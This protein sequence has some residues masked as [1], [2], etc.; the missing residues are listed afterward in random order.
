MKQ[1]TKSKKTE[2]ASKIRPSFNHKH[3]F[4]IPVITLFCLI[5]FSL[6][7]LLVFGGETI[8]PADSKVVQLHIDGKSQSIPT[9]AATVRELLDRV[10]IEVLPDDVVEP[11][12]DTPITSEK[13]S[14]N[15]YRAKPVVVVDEKGQKTLTKTAETTPRIIAKKAGYDLYPE[16]KIDIV[17]PDETLKD[18]VIGV[19]VAIDR[20]TPV[21]MNLYGTT[22]DIRTHAETVA[23]LAKERGLNFDQASV[24]PAPNTP[25]RAGELIF[26]TDPGK[27]IASAEEAIPNQEEV[28][29]D[30]GLPVG[31][32]QVRIEGSAGRKAIVYELSP[33]G[34]K[35]ILQEIVVTE[36]VK[37]VV[38]K[39]RRS[40]TPNHS[41]A[42]DKAALMSQAGIPS[43]QQTS[44][45]YI[46]SRESGWRPA[47]RSANNCIGLGQR[48]NASILIK[49]CPNWETDPQCQLRHFNSYAVGRYGSWDKAYT[50]W[51]V[52]HWW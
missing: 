42:A 5:V 51:S 32:T 39:G 3:P 33:D 47:A 11:S 2:D 13:F 25:L 22:F 37:R 41:V 16:D 27:Q 12:I 45:D 14:I 18:G 24:L 38:V 4:A 34:K 9:R 35:K 36:P 44:A 49:A 8:G 20:A 1:K 46:I 30:Q 15:I 40:T 50:F 19:Q 52:N 26:V 48:C 21:K 28:I 7:G 43:S 23:D 17:P 6:F 31:T 29:N 10:K